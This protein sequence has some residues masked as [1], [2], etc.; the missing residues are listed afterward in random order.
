MKLFAV[1]SYAMGLAFT[2]FECLVIFLQAY[3]FTLLTAVYID[4]ATSAE[5]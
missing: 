2:L 1:P 3:I 5:H 4:G